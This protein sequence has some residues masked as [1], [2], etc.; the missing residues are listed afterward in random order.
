MKLTE[1]NWKQK[2]KN[3][4]KFFHEIDAECLENGSKLKA[5]LDVK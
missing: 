4:F 1:W 2:K 5:S 3:V